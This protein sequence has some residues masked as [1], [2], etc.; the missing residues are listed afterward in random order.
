MLKVNLG[1]IKE[2]FAKAEDEN[3]NK[4]Y[5]GIVTSNGKEKGLFHY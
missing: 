2:R 3:V 5:E 1:A 4:P